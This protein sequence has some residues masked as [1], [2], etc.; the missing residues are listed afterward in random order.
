[1]HNECCRLT[2]DLRVRVS[3]E[4]PTVTKPVGSIDQIG[5][6]TSTG[7]SGGLRVPAIPHASIL[8]ASEAL[9]GE[10][11]KDGALDLWPV[12]LDDYHPHG[13]QPRSYTRRN[14]SG[15]CP[16]DV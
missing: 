7:D 11:G 13:V 14:D 16:F 3:A 2:T 8:M 4:R 5:F 15:L 12:D 9:G 10:K 1:M 6:S